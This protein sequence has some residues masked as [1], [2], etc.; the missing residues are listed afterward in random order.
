[1]LYWLEVV[2]LPKRHESGDG[3]GIVEDVTTFLG[4]DKNGQD[5]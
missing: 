4:S 1:M 5:Q 3:G 2:V